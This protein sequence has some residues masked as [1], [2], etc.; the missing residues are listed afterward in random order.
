MSNFVLTPNAV[1]KLRRAIA[2][3]SGNTGAIAATGVPID[4]DKFPPP[5]TVRW[6]ASAAS[7]AGAWVIWLP[8]KAQ[9]VML[10]DAY[11]TPT[12]VTAEQALP[13]GW[14]TIDDAAA[15]STEVYLNIT[16]PETGTPSAEISTTQGQSTTGET[17]MSI[18]VA[19][20]ETDAETGAKRVKQY[21]D[22]A[23]LVGSVKDGESGADAGIYITQE[24]VS[25]S[26]DH[27]G[28]GVEI[29]LQPL[30]DGVPVG[31]PEVVTLWNGSG[32]GGGGTDL[33]DTPALD[34]VPSSG[35]ASA[36]VAVTASRADHVH[37]MPVTVVLT[38]TTQTITGY[39]T[40]NASI[41]VVSDNGTGTYYGNAIYLRPNA[42][43]GNYIN[44]YADLN[45]TPGG[46]IAR[47]EGSQKSVTISNDGDVVL[48]PGSG[49]G[50][51][52]GAN[53]TYTSSANS[54]L[55]ATI[56]LLNTYFQKMLTEGDNVSIT[57][58][59]NNPNRQKISVAVPTVNNATLTIVQGSTTLGTFTANQ[60]TPA[61]ITI[62]EPPAIPSNIV[63]T[64]TTQTITGA[65]TF[66]TFV[67]VET[68]NGNATYYGNAIY[69]RPASGSSAFIYLLT[70]N[71]DNGTIAA[72]IERA[73]GSNSTLY[74]RNDGEIV[75]DAPQGYGVSLSRTPTFTDA[76]NSLLVPTL[77]LIN[78]Y[79]Q[80]KRTAAR[81]YVADIMF[82]TTDH[83][84]KKLV[85]VEAV[86]G[87]VSPKTGEGYV[88]GWTTIT[89]GSTT[90]ISSILNPTT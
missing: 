81:E 22:S 21:V 41:R 39:K 66:T 34:V 82:D 44:L 57:T 33:S 89:G 11:I 78:T 5:F 20:M 61:T 15:S 60:A 14:Y 16:I 12:G 36:G 83:L 29:T 55:V 73:A 40:F 25:P 71:G 4:L 80:R 62:P 65:K 27:P 28:G 19:E 59:P 45:G 74:F 53:P 67:K 52:L 17:V 90:G 58:D 1:A 85:M 50:V 48:T 77:G 75:I 84:F 63:F 6:S 70:D 56:G 9:L 88:N 87:T 37:K 13:A 32:G 31:N 46:Q 79:F 76:T 18:L 10:K 8:D 35:Q 43:K 72:R 68:S 47:A 23:A 38:N 42:T 64:N 26:T 30:Q 49:Y 2:P 51:K 3:R 7:G 54:L 86:D 24:P 69:L